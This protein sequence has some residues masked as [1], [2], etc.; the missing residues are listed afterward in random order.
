MFL[1]THGGRRDVNSHLS[2][3]KH[4]ATVEAAASSSRATS[5]FNEIGSSVALALAAKEATFALLLM[6]KVL[7]VVI[8]HPSWSQNCLNLNSRYREQSVKL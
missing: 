2:S 5:F 8:A 7:E 4:K 3:K 6:G 1:I